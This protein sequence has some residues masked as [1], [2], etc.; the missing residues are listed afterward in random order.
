MKKVYE[1]ALHVAAFRSI[2]SP[3]TRT[4]IM[5]R[6]INTTCQYTSKENAPAGKLCGNLV[7]AKGKFLGQ[8]RKTG[9]NEFTVYGWDGI[10][11]IY[12]NANFSKAGFDRITANKI[13]NQYTL[14]L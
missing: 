11:G 7:C 14:K 6:T 12:Q 13:I 3:P 5:T 2:L 8:I 9:E 4:H 10:V 1:T